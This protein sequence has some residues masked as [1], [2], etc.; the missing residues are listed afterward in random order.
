[1]PENFTISYF[2]RTK[3]D[4]SLKRPYDGNERY[5]DIRFIAFWRQ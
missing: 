2:L 3:G 1:M 5:F 4:A